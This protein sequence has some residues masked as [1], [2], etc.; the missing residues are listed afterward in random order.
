VLEAAT[1]LFLEH[2]YDGA[3]LGMLIERTGG[4]K[5]TIYEL[6]GSK[7]ALLNA[8]VQDR[9]VCLATEIETLVLEEGLAP[10]EILCKL[11]LAAAKTI[12]SPAGV[13]LFRLVVQES[14][15]NPALGRLMYEKGVAVSQTL[16]AEYFR[17]E[18]EAG[19]LNVLHPDDASSMFFSMIKGD[20]HLIALF[21]GFESL[22]DDYL[23]QRVDRAVDI[24]LEG[25]CA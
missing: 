6:F 8:I 22:T 4:S 23:K 3:T 20:S 18:T 1:D 2:G 14:G 9:C 13:K 25:V 5:R 11:G 17:R 16:L 15:R 12:L 10:R 19:R 21:W 7:E 24:F